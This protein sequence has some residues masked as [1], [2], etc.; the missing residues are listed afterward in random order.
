MSS[1]NVK[2]TFMILLLTIFMFVYYLP[3]T[4]GIVIPKDFTKH[5]AKLKILQRASEDDPYD[6]KKVCGGFRF[7]SPPANGTNDEPLFF[8][9]GTYITCSWEKEPSSQVNKVLDV[10]LFTNEG[11]KAILLSKEI[12]MPSTQSEDV[13]V[14]LNVPPGMMLPQKFLLRSFAG[15]VNGPHCTAYT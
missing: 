12:P 4:N 5:Q 14:F 7:K 11:L 6:I 13:Q 9:N 15:T 1:W 8:K 2:F 10:E 3:V